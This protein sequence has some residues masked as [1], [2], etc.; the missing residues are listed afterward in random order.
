VFC[1]NCGEEV[2]EENKYCSNCGENLKSSSNTPQNENLDKDN[3]NMEFETIN[4]EDGKLLNDKT[5][6]YYKK[7]FVVLTLIL[8]FP[9]GVFLLWKS[10]SFGKK[11]K[12]IISGI[13]FIIFFIGFIS[14]DEEN[15]T[16]VTNSANST[17]ETVKTYSL[18]VALEGK[19]KI[20][21]SNQVEVERNKNQ[22]ITA[23]PA[24]GWAFSNWENIKKNG[25]EITIR[26][27]SN[28]NITAVFEEVI[29][30]ITYNEIENN[31]EKMTDVQ[32]KN[33]IDSI[34]NKKVVWTGHIEEVKEQMTN[35]K[36]KVW[37]DVD[38][39]DAIMSTQEVYLQNIPQDV[40]I[41]LNKGKVIKFKG[42]IV[43]I[44]DFM[45]AQVTLDNVTIY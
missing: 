9:I 1:P 37:I 38:S 23:I 29:S 30:N 16:T 14:P 45:T 5:K 32:F 26:M 39:T 42:E 11:S 20:K 4:N 18:N 21:P 31:Y 22:K 2:S 7:W 27:D 40:A 25:N 3:E 36:Y 19:G 24:E 33:Y 28:K 44:S 17:T 34:I 12:I 35:D 10:N 6:W 43:S 8:F 15:S 13:I 41:E